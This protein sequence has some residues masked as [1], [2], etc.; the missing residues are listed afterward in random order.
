M[1]FTAVACGRSV[2][3]RCRALSVRYMCRFRRSVPLRRRSTSP[4]LSRLSIAD[5]AVGGVKPKASAN[6]RCVMPSSS[7]SRRRNNH[8]LD[9]IPWLASRS[10]RRAT[11]AWLVFR[12]KYPKLSS[13][14]G[15]GAECSTGRAALFRRRPATSAFF[16]LITSNTT[17][18]C[19]L[20]RIR[21]IPKAI[22]AQSARSRALNAPKLRFRSGHSPATADNRKF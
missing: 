19:W 15:T 14:R 10:S 4:W 9:D 1:S 11:I 5:T 6:S 21:I 2:S 22:C 16:F 18:A 8:V 12:T 17:L 20:W 7:H 3:T 13:S